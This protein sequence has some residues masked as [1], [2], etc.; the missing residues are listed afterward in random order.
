MK[1]RLSGN[2]KELLLEAIRTKVN[3]N[4][5]LSRVEVFKLAL[6]AADVAEK[7]KANSS[8]AS[9]Y[10]RQAQGIPIQKP[11]RV[12]APSANSAYEK[13]HAA[14]QSIKDA[15]KDLDIERN[16][17][18]QRIIELDNMIAKYRKMI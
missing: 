13:I 11:G 12:F 9:I 2:E 3:E 17:L 4:P 18:H 14:E 6:N 1:T 16:A 8:N 15:L 7:L 5:N 10:I